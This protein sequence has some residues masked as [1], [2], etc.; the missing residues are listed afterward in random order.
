M[1]IFNRQ[2]MDQITQKMIIWSRGATTLLTDFRVGS[3]TRTLY[4]AFAIVLEDFYDKTFKGIKAAIQQNIYTA[5][6]FSALPAVNATGTMRF[7]AQNPPPQSQPFYIP[8]GTQV[9]AAPTSTVGPITFQTTQDAYIYYNN[10]TE[11]G[12]VT[13]GSTSLT[14]WYYVDIPVVCTQSGTIGNVGS[15]QIQTLVGAPT[16]IGAVNNGTAFTSGQDAESLSQ[17]KARFQLFWKS[18]TRGTPD[19]IEYGAST[20][21]VMDPSNTYVQE[22]VV[23]AIVVDGSGSFD[24]YLWNGVGT[25]SATLLAN[26]TQ[27]ITGYTDANGNR[28]WGYKPAG[29]TFTSGNMHSVDVITVNLAMTVTP[30]S[31]YGI[32]D[33]D[34]T[35]GNIDLRPAIQNAVS[36]YFASLKP[37]QTAIWSALESAIK[38]IPGVYDV[39]ITSP[40]GNTT[41]T[42]TQMLVPSG[43]ITYT[44]GTTV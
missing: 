18:R 1:A 8:A 43:S 39:Q 2:T 30:L 11:T 4:E 20:A 21:V 36:A 26:A 23:S 32:T 40:T 17:Q 31:G 35:A 14:G 38:Q 24:V 25:A 37:G 10:S 12:N 3:K 44:K 22:R 28:V 33:A 19:S 41:A 16:G 29:I 34:Q 6:G 13:V 7:Y 9:Q 5:L 15:N 42:S 27:I